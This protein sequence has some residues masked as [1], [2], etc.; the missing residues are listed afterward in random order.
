MTIAE[1]NEKLKADLAAGDLLQTESAAQ[2]E[3]L[4][5][6]VDTLLA[7]AKTE[8]GKVS[9]RMAEDD[10]QH[11]AEIKA[12]RARVDEIAAAKALEIVAQQGAEPADEVETPVEKTEEQLWDEY[13]S[14]NKTNPKEATRF[15]RSKIRPLI[16]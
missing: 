6:K 3:D 12:E 5:A 14:I 11:A 15:Y 8:R 7:A 1:E 13:T 10:E 9:E 2:V 16:K 4:Q